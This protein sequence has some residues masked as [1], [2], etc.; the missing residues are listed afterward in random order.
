MFVR[1]NCLSRV[2]PLVYDDILSNIEYDSIIAKKINEI[3]EQLA[4]Y[5]VNIE[6]VYDATKSYKA[7]SL[8]SY[9]GALY[10]A[11]QDVPA[12][13]LPTDTEYWSVL[14]DV[15]SI[16]ESEIGDTVAKVAALELA[17]ASINTKM[18]SKVDKIKGRKFLIL[19]DSYAKQSN[20]W[21]TVL[22]N[23]LSI[24]DANFNDVSISG[25]GFTIEGNLFISQLQNFTGDKNSITDIIV[26]GGL[27]DCG[28]LAL[29]E[30]KILTR[31]TEFTAYAKANYPNADI[32]VFFIGNALDGLAEAAEV[33]YDRGIEN[34]INGCYQYST[35]C[36]SNG[37]EFVDLKNALATNAANFGSDYLHPSTYGGTA[38]GN[39]ISNYLLGG[40]NIDIYPY[41]PFLLNAVS[42]TTSSIVG[43]AKIVND[44]KMTTVFIDSSYVQ[45]VVSANIPGGTRIKI[46]NTNC[47]FNKVLTKIV[48][49]QFSS[50]DG[51]AFQNVPSVLAFDGFG[52]YITTR[53]L[54]AEGTGYK[55]HVR[56]PNAAISIPALEMSF[57]T[58]YIN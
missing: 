28:T 18:G 34:R 21:V 55:D 30:G 51:I 3:I 40:T 54:N 14:L 20:P 31:I 43:T 48:D 52:I 27:N 26:G 37:I 58:W 4:D 17:V 22:K 38:I 39:A 7:F 10:T 6:G 46:A 41:Y 24:T 49:V 45:A 1:N 23:N 13:I 44:D 12:G 42:G 32:R 15:K 11:I 53:D 35:A 36:A 16:I 2:V 8:V 9:Q 29:T 33:L 56:N 5:G 50:F 25:A 19:G 47:Y 57:P